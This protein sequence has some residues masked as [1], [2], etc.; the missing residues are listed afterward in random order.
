MI[1]CMYWLHYLPNGGVQWLLPPWTSYM[2]NV[3]GI[4]PAH[5]RSHQNG[6]QSWFIF[7]SSL[8]LLLPWQPLGQYRGSSCL[9]VVSSGF[10]R[11]PEHA[12]SGNAVCIALVH[13]HGH[14]N[15]QQ[16]R[17]FFMPPLIL[18]LT[19]TIAKDHVMVH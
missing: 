18:S 4:V 6:Q 8:C 1:D 2:G 14:Q 15:G 12:A 9:M 16:R 19:I 7:W 10:R 5:H 17:N 13:H 11:S 3:H